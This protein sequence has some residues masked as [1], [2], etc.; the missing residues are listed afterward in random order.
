VVRGVNDYFLVLDPNSWGIQVLLLIK[1][2]DPK[3]KVEENGVPV[4]KSI[5][6]ESELSKIDLT[7]LLENIETNFFVTDEELR[8]NLSD[9]EYSQFSGYHLY[10][11]SREKFVNGKLNWSFEWSMQVATAYYL[12]GNYEQAQLILDDARRFAIEM[13]LPDGMLP[14]SNVNAVMNYSDYGWKIPK[15]PSFAAT[16]TSILLDYGLKKAEPS[17]SSPFFPV[18]IEKENIGVPSSILPTT[19]KK[20]NELISSGK[21]SLSKAIDVIL[22]NE[23]IK[24][25]FNPIGFINN[26]SQTEGAQ[27]LTLVTAIVFSVAFGIFL[28]YAVPWILSVIASIVAALFAN[29]GT[30]V[31]IDY[32]YLKSIGLDEAIKLY[33]KDNV[34]LTDKGI[35]I[36]NKNSFKQ[37]YV[38][39]DKPKNAKDFNFKSVPIKVK[40]QSGKLAKCWIGNYN[41]TPILFAEGA[42]Y[43]MI[44]EEFSKTKQFESVYGK[45]TALKANVDVIEI[46]MNNPDSSL[47]Y[48]NT[49][50]III[51]ANVVK[52]GEIIDLQKEISLLNNKKIEA[53]TINQNIAIYIDDEIDTLSTSQD[54]INVIDLYVRNENLGVDAKVLFSD[55]YINRVLDLLEQEQGSKELAQQ[56][57]IEIIK[58]LKDENKEV[59]V[60]FDEFTKDTDFSQYQQYGI[61]SYIAGNEYVDGITLAKSQTKFVTNLSQIS[62]FDG[63][64]SIIKVSLFRKEIEQSSGIFTFLTSSLNLKEYMKKRSIKFIKQVAINFDYNQLPKIDVDIIAKILKSENIFEDLKKYLSEIDSISIYYSGLSSE[65]EKSVFIN[66]II[67]RILVANYLRQ[68]DNNEN[69]F[70]LKNK[71]MEEIL[72]AALVAK[73]NKDGNFD[74]SSEVVLNENLT[75]AQFEFEFEK[76]IMN[77]V[78]TGFAEGLSQ[79]KDPQSIDDII[80]LIPLYAERNTELRTAKVEVIEIQNFKGILSAA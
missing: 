40:T 60:I 22:N 28:S 57:L 73:Y 55:K 62:C 74:I 49:G 68:F 34:R 3:V 48:S 70:G 7:S 27:I 72:A 78:S 79:I 66:A 24:S 51:G 16:I 69:S 67:E 37:I 36:D 52:T 15:A 25:L 26:H 31:I 5:Y 8:E 56:K 9:K 71:K 1:E 21:F 30:H 32:R 47:R 77:K 80:K 64:L 11:W 10:T 14:A 39:N 35:S 12:M 18:G 19:I 58:Q 42:N 65:E 43:G 2:Y 61:F 50:N 59:V 20:L 75:A 76:M 41:G 53:V 33:G 4:E 6:E 63:S 54:F 38:I 45:K 17:Y 13:D 46:D 29:I 44:V 23:T